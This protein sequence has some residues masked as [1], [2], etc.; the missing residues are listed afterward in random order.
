VIYL[1]S[2]CEGKEHDK[3]IL[4]EEEVRFNEKIDG[5][6]DLAYLNLKVKNMTA[7]IPHKKPK[8]KELTAQQKE[9]N[10]DKSKI[11]VGVEHAISGIKRL[12]VLKYKLRVKNYLQH[13]KLILLGCALHNLR[14]KSRGI[15]IT[16]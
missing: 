8:G 13:D 5:Y 11:R 1:G 9:E 10:K 3:T 4:E 6:I 16:N 2:T 12:F 15:P 7:I 14:I